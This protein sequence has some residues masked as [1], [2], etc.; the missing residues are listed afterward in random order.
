[1]DN[2]L[3]KGEEKHCLLYDKPSS[4]RLSYPYPLLYLSLLRSLPLPLS[5]GMINMT[6][7]ARKIMLPTSI[8]MSPLLKLETIKRNAHITKSS[9]PKKS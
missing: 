2:L 8:T 9:H 3:R 1:M 6:H 7:A 5:N 4:R